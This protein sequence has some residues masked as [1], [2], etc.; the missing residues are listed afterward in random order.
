MGVYHVHQA[1]EKLLKALCH[2]LGSVPAKTHH[3]DALLSALQLKL[4]E[5]TAISRAVVLIDR[6]LPMLRYPQGTDIEL[7]DFESV[8]SQYL[9]IKSIVLPLIL[10]ESG[11]I[12]DGEDTPRE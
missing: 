2:A 5:L 12:I 4:P 1:T 3:L 10:K 6:Y 7:H 8:Y 9:Q 11:E